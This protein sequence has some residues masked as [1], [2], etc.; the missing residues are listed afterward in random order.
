MKNKNIRTKGESGFTLIELVIV[1]VILSILSLVAMQSF[2]SRTERQRARATLAEME[3]LK[4]AIVG[5]PD[6]IQNGIRVDFGY[7]GDVGDLPPD[8]DLTVLVSGSGG[9]WNGPYV[10]TDFLDNPTDYLFDAYGERYIWNYASMTIYSPGA[11]ATVSIASS[12]NSLFNNSIKA[13][14]SDRNGYT[15][16]A[17]D[18]GNISVF[19][20]LQ[21][22]GAVGSQG[23]PNVDVTGIATLTGVPIG[24]HILQGY[25]S[26]I[27]TGE[28][29]TY[30]LSVNPGSGTI[31][32]EVIFSSLPE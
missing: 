26:A 13:I 10:E 6:Q 23:T 22:G 4:M 18:V 25:H 2:T 3:M 27:G 32:R 7:A 5:D 31:I 14:I 29:V 9:N 16:S 11:D 24:N 20:S 12:W 17:G 21:N 1:V 30:Y 28:T 15:P 19:I 8:D